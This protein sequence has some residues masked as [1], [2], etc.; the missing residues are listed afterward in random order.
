MVSSNKAKMAEPT[1]DITWIKENVQTIHGIG[2]F[3]DSKE[4]NC[5][6]Y[7][8]YAKQY[9]LITSKI[10]MNDQ[11]HLATFLQQEFPDLPRDSKII[12]F[13]CGT[14]LAGE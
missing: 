10:G 11:Y 5:D 8:S 3:K 6:H 4:E 2:S 1:S 9:D 14:G 12:D 7:G 13:G